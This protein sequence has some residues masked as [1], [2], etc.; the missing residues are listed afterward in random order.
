MTRTELVTEQVNSRTGKIFYLRLIEDP[1]S[2]G[3]G[4]RAKAECYPNQNDRPS[5]NSCPF[6]NSGGGEAQTCT[7]GSRLIVQKELK[8]RCVN[9]AR[10]INPPPIR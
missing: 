10:C 8:N 9:L 7:L 4:S 6:Y 3:N 2:N 5:P 1:D